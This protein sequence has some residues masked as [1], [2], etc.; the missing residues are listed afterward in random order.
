MI[1][2]RQ[3]MIATGA[4]AL[5]AAGRVHAGK[6]TGMDENLLKQA[7]SGIEAKSGG[8]LG[9]AVRDTGSGQH[10][11]HRGDERFAMC[12]TFKYLLAA[13]ILARVD[14][15]EE[16]H[17]RT[18][19][20]GAGDILSNSPVTERHVG[21]ALSMA[22]LCEAVITVSD[23]AGANLL[24]ATI[25]GPPGFT[26][27]LR[28]IGDEVTRLDRYELEMSEAKPGDPRDTTSPN[29][30]LEDLDRLVLGTVLSNA[31][32]EKLTGWLIANKTGDT[33]LRAGLPKGWRVGD[34]TGTGG[35]GTNNDVAVIWPPS[36]SPL[37]VASYLT[38]SR[39]DPAGRNAVHADVARAVVEAVAA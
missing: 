1:S 27:F 2:R 28:G 19:P 35:H 21:G 20:V 7:I 4:A 12:S 25:D 24:L 34:K 6:T 23:N 10:F 33:R 30:I 13:A 9:V 22:T 39:L 26:G 14:K 3:L 5:L 37:L 36:A 8:R 32:R 17:D 31:S 16:N 15:G 18:L 38:E 29:A 11:S